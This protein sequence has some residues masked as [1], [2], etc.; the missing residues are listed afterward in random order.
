MKDAVEATVKVDAGGYP[1]IPSIELHD[2]GKDVS[3]VK[4]G[5]KVKIVTIKQ[6]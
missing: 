5:N 3:L 2:Y 1:Y 4:A 6:D